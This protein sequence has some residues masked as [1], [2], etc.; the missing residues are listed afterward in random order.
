VLATV[1]P[2]ENLIRGWTSP[3]PT[4]ELLQKLCAS[5]KWRGKTGQDDLAV[6]EH[7]G[8]YCDLQSLNSE[9]AI[10]WSFFGPL[11]YGE[12]RDR[13]AVAHELF[14][15]IGLPPPGEEVIFWL[16]RRLPHPE[17]PTSSGGPEVDFGVQSESCCVL[18]EAKWNSRMGKGQGVDKN[19]SQLGL[20]IKYCTSI[21]FGA[22]P[23]VGNW[24]VLGVGRSRG[25]F[26]GEG[27]GATSGPVA[28]SEMT[29]QELAECF[30]SQHQEE[31][32]V[33]LQWKEEHSSR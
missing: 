27:I 20:R 24:A 26:E 7:L 29:W 2:L 4:P 6:R 9:D 12:A 10:T 1:D 28:V 17:K 32:R 30:H 22:L 11:I 23:G 18:G 8:H 19:R 21:G 16:W 25:I 31:L 5:D 13:I 3:W 15:R 14:R 33:Y